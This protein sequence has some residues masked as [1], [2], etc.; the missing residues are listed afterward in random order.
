MRINELARELE[1]KAKTILEY[2][3]E[4]GVQEKKSHSSSIEGELVEKVKVHFR[5]EAEAAEKEATPEPTAAPEAPAAT[6][7]ESQAPAPAEAGIT[8][9]P[10][11]AHS[12]A[13]TAAS[14]R[15]PASG[16]APA[17]PGRPKPL[18]P[19]IRIPGGP[20]PTPPPR[21]RPILEPSPPPG[22]Q[23]GPARPPVAARPAAAGHMAA[24]TPTVR[25]SGKPP[26][27]TLP[28]LGPAKPGEPIYSR[29]PLRPGGR[30]A[31]VPG[32]PPFPA[33]GPLRGEPGRRGTHPVRGRPHAGP[34]RGERE[35]YP[36]QVRERPR[37]PIPVPKPPPQPIQ[38]NREITITEGITVKDL[39][40]R[41]GVKVR[42]LIR[43]L[44]DLG[45]LATINQNLEPDLAE[46]VA[47]SFGA[48]TSL[49][50]FEEESLQQVAMA[51][52]PGKLAPRAPVV[53]VMGH[54]DH[55]K[56]SLLDAIRETNV[57]AQ[58]SGG[59]T[60]HIGAYAVSTNG[61]KV[62]FLDTPGHEAFTRMRA[63]GSKVT[64][65]VVLVVAAD[66]GVMPQTLEAIN[67]ARAAKVPILVAINKIDKPGAMPDRA[68]K[69]LSEQGLVCEDW[70]GDTVMVE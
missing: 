54:V 60:Q 10:R 6:A 33:G 67:H 62:V 14:A 30:P 49:V 48:Q 69:Q 41:L 36:Q 68:K 1:V 44:L 61:R 47:K 46:Q 43:R 38:I 29:R 13:R 50:S 63:R 65:V 3:A 16:E 40:K 25:P 34:S 24:G 37:R 4:I 15:R 66:D 32:A 64:D 56:T 8:V 35:R 55:G 22:V 51:E 21:G 45:V 5:Q 57:L 27:K 18:R 9:A 52:T 70:G 2:L 26:A 17:V 11:E 23:P 59:I 42:D 19:P 28:P 12:E 31:K 7:P 39:S 20:K 53:T 58:E